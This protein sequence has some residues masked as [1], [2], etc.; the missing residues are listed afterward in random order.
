VPEAVPVF[1]TGLELVNPPEVFEMAP[2]TLRDTVLLWRVNA[3]QPADLAARLQVIDT[4]LNAIAHQEDIVLE[5]LYPSARWQPG[6]IVP[7]PHTIRLPDT[8]PPGLYRWGAGAY[9]TPFQQ[10]PQPVHKPPVLNHP[11]ALWLWGLGRSGPAPAPV[12]LP[13]D[14]LPVPDHAFAAGVRLRGAVVQPGANTWQVRLYWQAL[15]QPETDLT[16]FVHALDAAGGLAG[17]DDR[18]PNNGL[19]P[20]WSWRPGEII[21]TTH[22]LPLTTDPVILKAGFY[23]PLTQVRVAVSQAGATVPEAALTFWKKESPTKEQAP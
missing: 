22:T 12:A 3:A 4:T 2:G 6:D 16:L 13:P 7:D 20:L 5:Y 17:Q 8:I 15:R 1:G 19:S 10:S 21:E 14:L 18:L 9:I 11:G 23:N